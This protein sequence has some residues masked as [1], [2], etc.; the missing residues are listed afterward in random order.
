MNKEKLDLLR[1]KLIILAQASVTKDYKRVQKCYLEYLKI[2]MLL[3]RSI[4]SYGKDRYSY[5]KGN[6]YSYALGLP[7]PFLI[8]F[9][10]VFNCDY[11]F[12]A[13][14]GFSV[15]KEYYSWRNT[16]ALITGLYQDCDSLGIEV[17][18][19]SLEEQNS[20]GGYKIALYNGNA[21]FHFMRQDDDGLW[22]HKLGYR[23]PVKRVKPEIVYGEG[24]HQ[25]QL[26]KVVEVV[27]PTLNFK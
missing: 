26:K 4:P 2:E 6:C 22:S 18:D 10:M 19:S 25:L 8:W 12:S 3:R 17:Y 16:E 1:K 21:D 23:A 9:S 11:G 14:P 15:D 20:H 7:T 5:H 13:K 27:K 24:E